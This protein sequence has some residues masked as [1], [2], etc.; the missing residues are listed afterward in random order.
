MSEVARFPAPVSSGDDRQLPR[1][2]E[3]EAAFLGAILIDN[4]VV[5]DLPVQLNAAHFFEPLHGRIF[6]Q[7]M[8]LI[9][10]NS[11]ATPV[12]LKPY[13]ENDE[14]MKAVGGVGY[15][16]QLTGSGAGL[17]GARDFARQIYDLALLRELVDVGR[18]MVEG[19][20]DT[21]ESVD[22]QAQ[23]EEAET[24]LYRVAGRRAARGAGRPGGRRG[25]TG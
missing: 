8:A 15:L 25:R 5:E 2:I 23:I 21:S 17:I 12:T 10:R 6:A 14:A 22:P 20:L 7:T 16:A 1:N 19:A 13:F 3:A 4:R 18:T 9:E 11:I 24:A